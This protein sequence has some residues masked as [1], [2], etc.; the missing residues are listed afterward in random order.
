MRR[1]SILAAVDLAGADDEQ[2]FQLGRDCP[3]L[4]DCAQVGDHGAQNLRAVSYR[5]EHVRNVA[6]Y[7]HEMVVDLPDFGGD[8]VAVETGNSGHELK[9]AK[10]AEIAKE[11]QN[12]V[13]DWQPFKFWQLP[14]LAILAIYLN[15]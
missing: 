5:A 1:Q 10:I 4:H 14:I 2:L 15:A 12:S 6:A 9:S 7:F 8:G 3:G 11:C 13:C